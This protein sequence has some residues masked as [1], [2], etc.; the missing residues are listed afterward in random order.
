MCWTSFQSICD[1]LLDCVLDHRI[2]I[3]GVA[4][5]PIRALILIKFSTCLQTKSG[6]NPAQFQQ[7]FW[8]KIQPSLS[9]E[10]INVY[11]SGC[12]GV[13]IQVVCLRGSEFIW[14]FGSD[15]SRAFGW[16]DSG[17]WAVCLWRFLGCMD[18]LSRMY[19]VA[20]RLILNPFVI[21]AWVEFA[22]H[23]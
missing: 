9:F 1:P 15:D 22:N 7:V 3:F 11:C 23:P 13:T 21:M 8:A 12:L 4:F 19:I 2:H 17:L 14:V 6:C 16:E 10:V 5:D 20:I 18:C